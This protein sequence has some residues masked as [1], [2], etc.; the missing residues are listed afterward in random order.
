MTDALCQAFADA[1]RLV[2]ESDEQELRLVWRCPDPTCRREV[3]CALRRAALE[4]AGSTAMQLL[5][6]W[7]EET[8]QFMLSTPHVHPVE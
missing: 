4:R 8:R 6:Q 1:Y 3:G 7:L 5:E 2:Y